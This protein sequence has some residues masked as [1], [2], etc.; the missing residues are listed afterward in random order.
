M[1]DWP[2]TTLEQPVN[3]V[4][5]RDKIEEE[6]DLSQYAA[7]LI[8][9][10]YWIAGL[11]VGLAIIAFVASTFLP[12]TY[13]ATALVTATQQR[14]QL[15]FDPRF[16]NIPESSIQAFLINQYRAYP[17]LATSD[18]L[19]QQVANESGR[20]LRDLRRALRAKNDFAL[21]TLTVTDKDA[22]E[23]ARIANIWAEAFVKKANVL[24]QGDNEVE[25]LKAQQEQAAQSLAQA[26]AAV[27]AFREEN[28]FGFGDSIGLGLIGQQLQTKK[29]LLVGYQ[30]DLVRINKMQREVELMSTDGIT[31]PVLIAGLLSQMI[32][33][34]AVRDN[35]TYQIKLDTLDPITGLAAMKTALASEVAATEAEMEPLPA[36]IAALHTQLAIKMAQL[37]QLSREK[38][39]KTETYMTLARKVQEVELETSGTGQVKIASQAA[40]PTEPAGLTRLASTAIGGMSG[41]ILSIVGVWGLVWWQNNGR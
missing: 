40:V 39:V 9:Y 17:T 23:A 35:P 2:T 8:K 33:T 3:T 12:A 1:N 16:Q 22:A 41:L 6:I 11:T 36:E 34:G 19:L 18:D 14:Y 7:G 10:W 29:D 38:E 37:E 21:F 30:V 31:S 28:G 24:Y 4:Q 26:D 5:Q 13:Q 15:Q 20:S 25:Q 27:T 32:N